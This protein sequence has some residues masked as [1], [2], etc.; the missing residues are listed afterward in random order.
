MAVAYQEVEKC[1]V[2]AVGVTC[3]T[4]E[5]VARAEAASGSEGPR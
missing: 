2:A 4:D 1:K 3:V 5:E